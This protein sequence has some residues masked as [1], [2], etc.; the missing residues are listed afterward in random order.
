VAGNKSCFFF[1]SIDSRAI[2]I[3]FECLIPRLSH[4]IFMR[5]CTD[6]ETSIFV[7]FVRLSVRLYQYG[8]HLRVFRVIFYW[9]LDEN[10]S[11]NS[12]VVEIGQKYGAHDLKT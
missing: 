2:G 12:N 7:I 9:R 1:A 10:I 6:V 3:F 4:E 11:S 8:S 5:V